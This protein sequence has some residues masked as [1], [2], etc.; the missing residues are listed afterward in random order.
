MLRSR[1]F[2]F[3]AAAV[4]LG[5]SACGDGGSTTTSG[6][7]PAVIHIGASANG[8]GAKVAASEASDRMMMPYQDITYVYDGTFP[9]LGTTAP[10]WTLPAGTE[11]DEARVAALAK[12]LG[13]EGEVRPLAADMGGG[14]MVGAQDYTTSNLTVSADGMLS[15][16]FNPMPVTTPG[17]GCAYAGSEGVAVDPAVAPD[18]ATV[19]PETTVPETLLPETIAPDATIPE[20]LCE[21]PEPPVGVPSKDEALSKGKALFTDMGYD[22]SQFEFD[23]YADEW[24]A[25]ITAY[26]MLGGHRSPLQMSVGFGENASVTWASGTL[27]EPQPAADYPLV[28]GDEALQ[29]L[30]DQS[31]MWAWYGGPGIM[32]KGGIAVD[33]AAT[34][35]TAGAPTAIAEETKPAIA[36]PETLATVPGDSV[37]DDPQ[38]IDPIPVESLPPLEPVTVHLNAMRLDVTMVWADDGTIWLL[39]A[40]T[41]TGADGGEYTIL[42][43]DDSFIDTPD[44]V[45]VETT[46]VDTAVP[47]SD[48]PA[49]TVPVDTTAR[50]LI[51]DQASEALVGLTLDE[52]TKVA[53]GNGWTVRVSV[54]DGEVQIGTMDLQPN[55]ANLAVENGIVTAVDSIG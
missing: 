33:A 6:S 31:G 35:A 26:R 44:P 18:A 16:W 47:G 50:A 34:T 7:T 23:T 5:L 3:A 43:V 32:A 8:G 29:R 42:A 40:Y 54:L 2:A 36:P 22:V 15:W 19:L 38:V 37:T 39:P 53:E 30:N 24:G 10:A 28:S 46:P 41:F 17:V 12:L 9:D 52:A 51:V 14:W 55:R 11:V 4:L 27:A 48:V 21:D 45:P 20:R 25:N 1:R 13:V 49:E